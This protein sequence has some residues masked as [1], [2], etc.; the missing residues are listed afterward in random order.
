MMMAAAA[1]TVM[2][3]MVLVLLVGMSKLYR[4]E[5]LIHQQLNILAND[6]DLSDKHVHCEMDCILQ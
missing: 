6:C 5:I 2:V 4:L 1:M 3:M